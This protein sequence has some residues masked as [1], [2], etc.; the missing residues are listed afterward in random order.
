LLASIYEKLGNLNRVKEQ[1][2]EAL[3]FYEKALDIGLETLP[4]NHPFLLKMH[5]F[6]GD[7]KRI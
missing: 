2:T 7:I 6:I 5:S 1:Y 4:D 3:D